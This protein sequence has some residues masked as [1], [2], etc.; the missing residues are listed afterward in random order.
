MIRTYGGRG[1]ALLGGLFL[2]LVAVAAP[3]R[4]GP[5]CEPREGIRS[6]CGLRAPEDIVAAPARGKLIFGQ[7]HEPGGL[8]MLDT[9]SHQ[10]TTLYTSLASS[11]DGELWGDP[12][13]SEPPEPL[14][15]HG[16]DL[17]RRQDGRWQ[18]LAVNHG[19]RESVEFF[20]LA[21]SP[22]GPRAEWRGCVPAPGD[23]SLNDVAGL[24]G[25]GF[26]VTR[27]SSRDSPN[28]ELLQALVGL[29]NSLVYRWT[30]DEGFTPL[31]GTSG[32]FP[33]GIILAPDGKS[34]YVN[35]Y[36][37]NRV[38]QFSLPGA[39]P[40]GEVAVTRPDNASWTPDGKLLVAS[41]H[42]GLLELMESLELPP[43]VPSMLPYEIVEIDPATLAS[44]RLFYHEGPPMGAGTVG[45]RVGEAVYVGSY[46]G[47]RIVRVPLSSAP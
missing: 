23:A 18:L 27:M 26:L 20:E 4:A 10:V 8:F 25:G 17:R 34:F 41:Q 40:L 47:D 13:C 39:E 28:W 15:V 11:G 30:R 35:M 36:L 44:R 42:G 32:R 12:A 31:P 24:P 37:G 3:D 1:S 38:R 5:G 45:V 21:S 33:N 19:E 2:V 29:D 7:M 6:I 16:I 9:G 43:G 14:L 22:A 46:V